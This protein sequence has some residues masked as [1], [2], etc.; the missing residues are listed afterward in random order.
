ML[1]AVNSMAIGM[2]D[3]HPHTVQLAK[4]FYLFIK[5][6]GQ[7]LR[8]ENVYLDSTVWTEHT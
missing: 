6:F 5:A 1:A 2:I 3:V 7:S 4:Y 8:S